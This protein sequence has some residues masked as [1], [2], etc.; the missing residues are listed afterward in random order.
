MVLRINYKTLSG[1]RQRS[2]NINISLF[3]ED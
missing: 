3:P 1:D 2:E